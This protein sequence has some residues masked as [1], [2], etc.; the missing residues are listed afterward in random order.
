MSLVY[1]L[2]G[3]LNLA[4]LALRVPAVQGP[5]AVMLQAAGLILLVVFGFKAALMP[6]SMWLPATYAA[7]SAPVTALFAIMTKVGVYAILRVHGVVFGG[8]QGLAAAAFNV[9]SLLLPL[10]LLTSVVAVLGA[11]AAHTLPRLLAWLTVVSVGTVLT[12]LG[13][14]GAAAWSAALYYLAQSTLV[15]AGL[16]LLAELISTQR[17]ETGGRLTS[18]QA[19]AQPQWLGM[20]LLFGAATVAG[21]PPLPGFIG[22]RYDSD[23]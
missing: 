2:T 18:G 14:G 1:A 8:D 3:T 4:D 13:V 7:A 21:L 10:A 23:E 9:Q 12:A 20:L 15:V 6:L 5:E 19:V 16:F 17:G 22:C 11:L